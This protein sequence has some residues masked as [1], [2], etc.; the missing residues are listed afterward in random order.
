MV[1]FRVCGFHHEDKPVLELLSTCLG[2]N[3]SGRLKYIL[4]EE[5]GLVYSAYIDD[6]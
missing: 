2:K 4:R 3:M 5:K 1:G 6:L